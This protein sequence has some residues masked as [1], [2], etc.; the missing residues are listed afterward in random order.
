MARR[1]GDTSS[2]AFGKRVRALRLQLGSLSQEDLADKAELHR[3]FIGRVERGETN[4]TL[5]NILR[6]VGALGI[7]VSDFFEGFEDVLEEEQTKAS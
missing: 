6:I 3:T 7:T 2:K 4:I 5:A 1:P